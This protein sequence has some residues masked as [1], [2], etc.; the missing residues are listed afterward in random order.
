MRNNV[1]QK[2]N[3]VFETFALQVDDHQFL[4]TLPITASSG[5]FSVHLNKRVNFS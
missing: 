5:P 4:F 1:V 2:V 3:E